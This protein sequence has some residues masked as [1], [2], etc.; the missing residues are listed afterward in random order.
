MIRKFYR[1]KFT[2]NILF[3]QINEQKFNIITRKDIKI[4]NITMIADN[5]YSV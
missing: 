4:L 3:I 5:L 1:C 2:N